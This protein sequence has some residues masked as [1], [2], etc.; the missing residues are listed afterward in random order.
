MPQLL[1]A[2]SLLLLAI[3]M[4]TNWCIAVLLLL[5]LLP[6]PELLVNAGF[7]Q[8][9]RTVSANGGNI[10]GTM[11]TRWGDTSDWYKPSVVLRYEMDTTIRFSGNASMSVACSSGFANFGQVI[12]LTPGR[13]YQLSI[14]VRANTSAAVVSLSLR[15]THPPYL[16]FGETTRAIGTTWQQ[17]LVDWAPLPATS[18]S[19]FW[20]LIG[21]GGPG[22][23]IWV[24]SASLRLRD[25]PP[26]VSVVPPGAVVPESYFCFNTNFLKDT[27]HWLLVDFS[28]WRTWDS[29]HEWFTLQ[30]RLSYT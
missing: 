16:V 22:S 2:F 27:P 5:T 15:Y 21:L 17:L 4:L 25:Q 29:G 7:D 18:Q 8:A 26:V 13:A 12:N 20:F 1:S 19:S 6:G 28:L 24:D 30:V 14:W 11:G 9:V 23:K 3:L 10:S